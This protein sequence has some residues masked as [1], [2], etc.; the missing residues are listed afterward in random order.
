MH[1]PERRHFLLSKIL[2][3][4]GP[5]LFQAMGQTL[6]LALYGLLFACVIGMIVGIMSVLHNKPC[7]I[8]AMIFVNLIR[9]VPMI[10]LAYFI[11]FGV[12]YLFNTI[13]KFDS[14]TLSALQAGTI[15]LALNCGAYMA[16]SASR[17]SSAFTICSFFVP[18]ISIRLITRSVVTT[19]MARMGLL[20]CVL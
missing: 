20:S 8:I 3:S 1:V 5:L 15:C 7:R 10:V 13:L 4:Y 12:P 14:V 19:A 9:G 6:L 16:A 2:L 11:Y 17:F 18:S